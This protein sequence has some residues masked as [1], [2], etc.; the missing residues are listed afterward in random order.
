M[1]V[2]DFVMGVSLHWTEARR[3][4]PVRGKGRAHLQKDNLTNLL[5]RLTHADSRHVTKGASYV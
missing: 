5:S 1:G 3:A 4:H 2:V